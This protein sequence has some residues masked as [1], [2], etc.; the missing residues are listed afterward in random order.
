M[1]YARKVQD[2]DDGGP[3]VALKRVPEE[4][5]IPQYE[6][7]SSLKRLWKRIS[8]EHKGTAA[9]VVQVESQKTLSIRW[10]QSLDQRVEAGEV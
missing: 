2:W 9:T 5:S 10:I 8:P 3:P 1:S 7:Q 4:A 6:I